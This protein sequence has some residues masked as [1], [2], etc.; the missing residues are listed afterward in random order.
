LLRLSGW[1]LL[2]T[3]L[4]VAM[5]R[6]VRT[7]AVRLTLHPVRVA[8]VGVV[9]LGAWLAGMILAAIVVQS[10][11]GAGLLLLGT[12][13]LLVAKTVGIVIAAWWLAWRG[14]RFLPVPLRAELPR[15]GLG[16]A[17]LVTASLLPGL[18]GVVWIAANVAGIGTITWGLIQ[19]LSTR[20]RP[21]LFS[22][23]SVSV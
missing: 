16:V 11:V 15:T 22:Y 7:G 3:L 2:A 12:L 8:L 4:I 20:V 19:R 21:L 14:A 18:G 1:V 13:L 9:T 17:I 23:V 5:P 10:P 6:I